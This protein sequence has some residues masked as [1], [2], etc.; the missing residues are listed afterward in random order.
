MSENKWSGD[1][2]PWSLLS[3]QTAAQVVDDVARPKMLA[4]YNC[5]DQYHAS[6]SAICPPAI[7]M[8][9]FDTKGNVG[10]NSRAR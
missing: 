5:P 10:N 7:Q 8:N 2:N 6:K 9:D 1:C 3:L 4:D